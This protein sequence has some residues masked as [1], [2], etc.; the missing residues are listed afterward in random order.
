MDGCAFTSAQA[1]RMCK[2]RAPRVITNKIQPVYAAPQSIS[3]EIAKEV[4]VLGPCVNYEDVPEVALIGGSGPRS[5]RVGYRSDRSK[6]RVKSLALPLMQE[7]KEQEELEDTTATNS[8]EHNSLASHLA[9]KERS[10]EIL[11]EESSHRSE[12]SVSGTACTPPLIGHHGEFPSL[13]EALDSFAECEVSSMGSSWLEVEDVSGFEDEG[14]VVVDDQASKG[15]LPRSWAARAKA[16]ST[17]GLAPAVPAAGVLAPPLRGTRKV[18][19]DK[20][21]QVESNEDLGWEFRCS[22]EYRAKP[23]RK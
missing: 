11:Y 14:V 19:P 1:E 8:F 15:E 17:K 4:R 13:Q 21:K 5:R 12:D 2:D 3:G 20:I 16:V 7:I 9:C 22:K 18:R 23:S 10:W 6:F